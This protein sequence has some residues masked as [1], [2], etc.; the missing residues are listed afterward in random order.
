MTKQTVSFP[1]LQDA[2]VVITGGGTG[3]GAALTAGF[4]AQGAK[5][6]FI[7]IADAASRALAARLATGHRHAPLF[8]HA[9]LTDLDAVK[10]AVAEAESAH[11][12]A[13]V[14]VNNAAVDDRHELLDM[15]EEY[16]DT[17][18]AI[19]LRPVA[20]TAKAVAP[21]MIAAGGGAIVNFTST[22]YMLNIGAMPSYTAAKAGIVGL[23]KGL[24]G[25]LGPDGIRVNAIAPGWVMTERQ[26]RLWVTDAGLAAMIDRQCLKRPI[27]PE[28][29]VGPC[30]F[31]ASKASAM[32]SAQ[33][34]IADGGMM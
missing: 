27:E 33:V 10:Q 28:D 2:A 19:N 1:D 15:S 6:A 4:A 14:L 5:V 29:M 34:L 11:G 20:F 12:A 31:L 30:L 18:Q 17:N 32:I 9:D 7:D 8:I 16:W 13:T 24:A 23:T 26:K 22:S 21:G 3:I 25:R